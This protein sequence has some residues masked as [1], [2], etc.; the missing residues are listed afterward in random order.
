M[1]LDSLTMKL[2]CSIMK[3][4]SST[5]KHDSST[6]NKIINLCNSMPQRSFKQ[7]L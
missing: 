2:G 7:I 5:I 3:V 6:M 4:G 1:K